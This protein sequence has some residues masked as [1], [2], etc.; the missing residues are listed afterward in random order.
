MLDNINVIIVP[1]INPDGRAI[2][3]Q[4]QGANLHRKNGYNHT[5]NTDANG[6]DISRNFDFLW[7]AEQYFE[8]DVLSKHP[9]IIG[10]QPTDNNYRGPQAVSEPET[11]NF[12]GLLD[13]FKN[14]RWLIDV[15]SLTPAPIVVYNWGD[16][17]DGTNASHIQQYT[18][19]YG[20]RA[21]G[22]GSSQYSEY[23]EQ[24]DFTLM[25]ALT[26]KA[27]N[28]ANKVRS[29]SPSEE[30][31]WTYGQSWSGV[32]PTC[33]SSDDYAFSRHLDPAKRLP[34]IYGSTM[35]LGDDVKPT[36]D[37]TTQIWLEAAGA[38]V[39]FLIEFSRCPPSTRG[40]LGSAEGQRTSE[41]GIKI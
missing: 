34:K 38:L 12:I 22:S 29:L 27:A 3:I 5:S 33:A 15:H 30:V 31:D 7:K 39:G 16:D 40:A 11:Q 4:T 36:W 41:F 26:G 20:K 28:Y 10:F 1:V 9:Q 24:S 13:K 2:T 18:Q 14:I 19:M 8:P 32:Y 37:D 35:E 23:V 17:H 25:K 21:I 6:V